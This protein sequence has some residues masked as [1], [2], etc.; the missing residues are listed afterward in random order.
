MATILTHA[1]VG[2]ALAPLFL[3]PSEASR[4]AAVGAI[5]AMIP[6]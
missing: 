1:V 2:A 5:A 6:D 4:W 3:H